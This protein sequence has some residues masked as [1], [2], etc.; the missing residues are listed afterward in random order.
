MWQLRWWSD[1]GLLLNTDWFGRLATHPMAL[2]SAFLV[3]F[4]LLSWKRKQIEHDRATD[5]WRSS[6]PR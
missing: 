4:L 2:A 5:P 1:F 6:L 3:A